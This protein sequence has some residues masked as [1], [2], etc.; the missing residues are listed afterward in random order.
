MPEKAVCRLPK[1][2]LTYGASLIWQA[3]DFA[4]VAP[5]STG[6]H[7]LMQVKA[8]QP[9]LFQH[10]TETYSAQPSQDRQHHTHEIGRHNRI[11]QRLT[12]TWSLPLGIST[13]D[14]HACFCTLVKVQR[15][16]ELFDTRQKDWVLRQETA[17]YLSAVTLS[18]ADAAHAVRAHWGIEN[19]LHDVR[20][21]TLG[22]GASRIRRNPGLF[23]LL[24]ALP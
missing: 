10:L 18:A 5:S 19:H 12:R 7:L 15:H 1:R 24:A 20:D 8:N 4:E 23:A 16:T 14:W 21:V 6:N 17:V 22:E 3:I 9:A 2:V 13:E 11:E